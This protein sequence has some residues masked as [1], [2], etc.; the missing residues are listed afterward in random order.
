MFQQIPTAKL[1]ASAFVP[2]SAAETFQAFSLTND[3][4]TEV[5]NFLAE[6]PLHTVILTG[7]VRDNGLVF[8]CQSRHFLW[9]S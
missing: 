7:F 3:A 2:Q 5:L 4:E 6:R 1:D 9:R 8:T